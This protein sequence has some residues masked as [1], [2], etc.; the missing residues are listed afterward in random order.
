MVVLVIGY[1]SMVIYLLGYNQFFFY[2]IQVG[3][4]EK[5]ERRKRMKR[6]W[7]EKLIFLHVTIMCGT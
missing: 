1:A 4:E 6:K 5:M 7:R 2:Y 3:E